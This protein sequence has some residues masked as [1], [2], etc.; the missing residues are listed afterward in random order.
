LIAAENGKILNTTNGGQ[1]WTSSIVQESFRFEEI[2]FVSPTNIW[3][4]GWNWDYEGIVLHTTNGGISWEDQ[5]P[6]NA[7]RLFSV[8]FIDSLNGW[9][10]SGGGTIYDIG[11]AWKTNDG[12]NSWSLVIDGPYGSFNK[13]RFVDVQT[14]WIAAGDGLL[15][16]TDGGDHWSKIENITNYAINDF[17]FVDEAKGWALS[18]F[19]QIVYSENGGE[20]W[21][22]QKNK[23]SD[24][25]LRKIEFINE[26]I[27]W[28]VGDFGSILHTETGGLTSV[29]GQ[30]YSINP[31]LS[32][33]L[34]QNYPNPFNPSTTIRFSLTKPAQVQLRVFN[35][36][37]EQVKV[38]V[39]NR[40][41]AGQHQ[42]VFDAS[43]L[44]SGVL[45]LSVDIG[46][47]LCF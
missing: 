46:R 20:T 45:L 2:S 17:T 3:I 9:V 29:N 12:G 43:K 25:S 21:K 28:A 47:V 38:L 41:G 42:A 32:F 18:L 16:T 15:K 26:N 37:G 6:A 19:G 24:F 39:D 11:R 13:V 5:T 10:T 1:T 40:L 33:Q 35:S 30:N 27:G 4:A 22:D 23:M 34:S 36:L 44:S 8:S 14:G 31:P 7:D